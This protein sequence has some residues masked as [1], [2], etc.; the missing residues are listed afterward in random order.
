MVKAPYA[1][2]LCNSFYAGLPVSDDGSLFPVIFI[3][4]AVFRNTCLGEDI[5]Y[6]VLRGAVNKGVPDHHTPDSDHVIPDRDLFPVIFCRF[7]AVPKD[8]CVKVISVSHF[9]HCPLHVF[10]FDPVLKL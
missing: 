3:R 1:V 5:L 8:Q 10:I 2:Y 7:S 9:K 4:Q 6:D